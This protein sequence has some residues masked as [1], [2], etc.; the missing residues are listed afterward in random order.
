MHC[1]DYY[2]RLDEIELKG[3]DVSDYA[4]DESKRFILNELREMEH[5]LKNHILEH[6]R[7]IMLEVKKYSCKCKKN[8]PD[9]IDMEN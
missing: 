2:G 4:V 9:N 3:K 7:I 1:H 8:V 6:K 5:R